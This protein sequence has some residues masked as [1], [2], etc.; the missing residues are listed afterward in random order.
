MRELFAQDRARGHKFSI[1]LPELYL[2]YSK[3]RITGETIGLLVALANEKRLKDAIDALF[4]GAIVNPSERRAALHVALRADPNLPFPGGDEDRMPEIRAELA[5]VR[6]LH[7]RVCAGELRG[8]SG[9]PARTFIHI[10]IGGSDLGPR[11]LADA[12]W[13]SR[14]T[15]V[16]VRFVANVDAADLDRALEGAAPPTTF[17]IIAS[18]SFATMETLVNA[19]SARD[20]LARNGCPGEKLAGHFFAVTAN[21]E[22]ARAFGI[23][24]DHLFR[25]WEWVGGRYSVWSAVGL[26]AALAIGF[27]RFQEFLAGARAMDRHFHETGFPDNLPVVLGLLDVWY[28]NFFDA[29][30][31]AIV[32]YDESLRLLPAYLTQL[33]MESNGKSVMRDGRPVAWHTA[34]VIL[35]AT[36]TNAQHSLFQF[37]HQGTRLVPVDLLAP[38]AGNGDGHHLRLYANCIAQSAALLSGTSDERIPPERRCPG[39]KPSNIML[40]EKLTPRVLGALLALYEHR[41]FVQ[42]CLWDINP[43]DQWGVETGKRL[44]GGI[45][46]ELEGGKSDIVHDSSTAALIERYRRRKGRD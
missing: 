24:E 30:A 12:L 44:A 35:G 45:V 25:I 33:I 27:D 4:A 41:T 13:R 36:G 26:A 3:N 15:A 39:N 2:D 22:A 6:A 19:G 21:F 29:H 16:D 9:R 10:G 7:D 42:A 18:K 11:L 17:F 8:F 38:L 28:N 46:A 23:R 1:E 40:Y 32:P 37:L 5:R 31:Q 34:P 43:F 20:W 14:N